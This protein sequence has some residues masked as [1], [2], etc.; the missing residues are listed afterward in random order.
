MEE[1]RITDIMEGE[2]YLFEKEEENQEL[3]KKEK[4]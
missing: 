1:N 3:G 2:S 4:A